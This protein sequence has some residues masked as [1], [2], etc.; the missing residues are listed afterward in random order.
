M[1][2]SE[3][4]AYVEAALMALGKIGCKPALTALQGA[5]VDK[6]GCCLDGDGDGVPDGIDMCPETPKGAN[7]EKVG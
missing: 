2:A 7:G 4:Q 6:T 1:L 3:N 5:K